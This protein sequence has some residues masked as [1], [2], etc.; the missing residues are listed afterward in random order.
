MA[1]S[2]GKNA[3]MR[4][5]RQVNP[6]VSTRC[7]H[8]SI[9]ADCRCSSGSSIQRDCGSDAWNDTMTDRRRVKCPHPP[10]QLGTTAH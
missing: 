10:Q 7:S 2:A 3:L 6:Q 8:L 9:K 1:A 5:R 4:R